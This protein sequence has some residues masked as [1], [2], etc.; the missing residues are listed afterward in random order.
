M[1]ESKDIILVVDYHDKNLVIRRFDYSTG[2]ENL[3]KR[4]T[5]AEAITKVVSD[6]RSEIVG[7]DGKVVWVME[8]T[9][10]WARVKDLLGSSA[11]FRMANVLQMP[12]PPKARRRKTDKID[13][14]RLLREYLTGTL[15][16]AYQ[17]SRRQREIRRLAAL[18]ESLV[19]RRTGV[20][21]WI[22]RYLAHETWENRS[23]L[24]SAKGM[25]WLK[26]FAA[27]L[28][29][30]D[31]VTLEMKLESLT[32]LD[33]RLRRVEEEMMRVYDAWPAAQRLDIVRGIGPISAV[34]ILARIGSIRRFASAEELI[35]YAGLAPGVHQ[36]DST[37]RSGRIGGGGTDKRLRHYIIEATLWAREIP[38]YRP[39]YERV[40]AKRGKKIGR[41]VVGR[42]LL[43][44]IYKMLRDDVHFHAGM[45]QATVL[46]N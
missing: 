46:A 18:R 17:P 6:A 42:M 32:F 26:A 11:A 10:G 22:D 43:R 38:R 21:N 5:T 16:L 28:G 31:R 27:S 25:R 1:H 23:G 4:P 12:L 14:A 44:S 3:F 15:P 13:T 8:S 7:Q 34:S 33:G 41:L 19:S 37:S 2:E 30:F 29:G 40:C 9:S 24:W 45:T 20:R 35:S 39:T 36:S